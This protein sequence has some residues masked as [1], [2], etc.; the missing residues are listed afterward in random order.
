VVAELLRPGGRFFMREAHP[1]L[2]TMSDPRPDG[3]LVVEFP[4]F[5]TD[6]VEFSEPV[7]YGGE[8]AL[9]APDIIH[10]NHGLSE[11]FNALSAAG[12]TV[13]AFDEH[14]EVPWNPLGDLMKASDTHHGEFVLGHG[15]DRLPL[16]YTLQAVKPA[17]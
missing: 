4:Y 10:F 2:W 13:T 3:L 16:S 8:G 7:T 9:A 5:E 11:I 15:P 1:M 17:D 6:G 14:R 12:L